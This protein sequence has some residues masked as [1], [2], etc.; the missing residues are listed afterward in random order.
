MNKNTLFKIRGIILSFFVL[1]LSVSAQSAY[2]VQTDNP[3]LTSEMSLAQQIKDK[4]VTV[5]I[6]KKPIKTILYEIQKQSGVSFAFNEKELNAELGNMSLNV[7]DCSVEQ[8]LDQLFGS[9]KYTYRLVGNSITIVARPQPTKSQTSFT[10]TGQVT[11][12]STKRPVAHATVQ[13][14]GTTIGTI[15]DTNGKY[16]LPVSVGQTVDVMFVGMKTSV[17]KITSQIKELN[18]VLTLDQTNIDNVV[19]TGQANIN[20]NSFT[21]NAKTIKGEDLLRASRTNVIKALQTFDPSFKIAENVMFGSDPNS[22]PDVYIRGRSSLGTFE[23]DKDKFSRNNM[24]NNPNTPTFIMDGFEVSIQKV[25]DLDPNRIQSVTILKDAAATAMYGSRAAN[26]VV[27]I[28]TIPAKDGQVR[29]NYNVTATME[30]PDLSDYNMMDA[31]EK[32][33]TELRAGVYDFSVDDDVTLY[34]R[35]WSLVHIEGVNTDWLSLPLRNAFKQKHSVTIDG[36]TRALQYGFNMNYTDNNG[37]M[38]ESGRDNVGAEVFLQFAFGSMSIKNTVSYNNTWEHDSPYGSFSDYTHKIPYNRIKDKNGNYLPELQFAPGTARDRLN[39]MYEATLGNF[40]KRNSEELINNLDIRW[41]ISE[42]WKATGQLSLSRRW[43]DNNRFVDPLSV[44]SSVKISSSNLLAGDLYVGDGASFDMNSRAGVSYNRNINKHNI[45]FN[46][47]GELIEQRSNNTSTHYV[48][49]PSSRLNSINYASG[50]EGKPIRNESTARSASV[51]GIFNYSYN[52]IYLLDA[53]IRHEG[54][55]MFGENQKGAFFW[56]GGVGI[57]LHNYDF[58]KDATA[59]SRFK[60]RASFGQIG[61]INFPPYAAQN[62][63]TSLFD[64]WYATGFGTKIEYLGNPNL[65]TERTNTLDAG[66]DMSFFNDRLTLVATY[67][68]KTTTDMINDVTIPSSSGF[69]VYKDNLGKVRNEGY[70]L[71]LYGSIMQT[72]DWSITVNANWATNKNTMLEIAESLK[73]YNDRVDDIYSSA[74]TDGIYSKTEPFR[75]YEEGGSLTSIFGMRSLGINPQNGREMF[76]DR[77]GNMIYDWTAGQQTILGDMESL[78][79]GSFGFNARYKNVTLYASFSYQYG[80]Q[81]YNQTLVDNV[82]NADIEN[83]NVD[84]RVLTDRWQKIGD[85]APLKDIKDSKKTYPTSRFVQDYNTFSLNSL[86]VMYEFGEKVTK[87]IGIERLRLEARADELFR[88]S[89]VKQERG[90]S[91]PFARSFHLSLMLNF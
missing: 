15:T 36:G 82:E 25:S 78:G 88:C 33:E 73:N 13:I 66:L 53:S 40:S 90:L 35:R 18:V 29:V 52:N 45:N 19:V 39:P 21:G 64:D 11:D 22:M 24:E 7:K 32:L 65:K 37:V 61:N 56:S 23:L 5:N 31:K 72:K 10:L 71:D 76:I 6:T 27:V 43:S 77:A 8:A 9:T 74:N 67:Y 60:I 81:T 41:D 59:I 26:G 70:E 17:N 14:S 87:P 4:L 62:Y 57:N 68:N 30:V 12:A 1:M 75:K 48:G 79:Q 38:K 55:S 51:T 3:I 86:S 47:N 63:Y 83:S 34:W 54:S 80:G 50:V 16:S 46:V 58:M 28:T 69:R 42:Y 20:R 91:Y 84:K 44:N 89:S 49:F 2:A 85:I